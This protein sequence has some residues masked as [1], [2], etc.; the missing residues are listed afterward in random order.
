MTHLKHNYMLHPQILLD[1]IHTLCSSD[2]FKCVIIL[3]I[4][5]IHDIPFKMFQQVN[6]TLQFV[7]VTGHCMRL[8]DVDSTMSAR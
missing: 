2:I 7:R 5:P 3:A 8:A 1:P 6:L 4:Q